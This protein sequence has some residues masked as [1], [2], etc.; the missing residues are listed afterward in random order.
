[1]EREMNQESETTLSVCQE[2]QLTDPTVTTMGMESRA[3][4]SPPTVTKTICLN[5]IGQKGD[6]WGGSTWEGEVSG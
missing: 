4:P 6:S 5:S 1:M 3:S 2:Y